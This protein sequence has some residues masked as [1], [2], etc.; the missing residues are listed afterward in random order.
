MFAS[1]SCSKIVCFFEAALPVIG[2]V[3]SCAAGHRAGRCTC[4]DAFDRRLLMLGDVRSLRRTRTRS[5]LAG[6]V[7]IVP[8]LTVFR[9]IFAICLLSLFVTGTA[10]ADSPIAA[11]NT[12]HGLAIKGYDPVSYYTTGKPTPG[13]TQFWTTYKGATYRFVSAENRDRFI[14]APEK[15]VPQYGGYCAYSISLNKIA[16]SVPDP[17]A[18]VTANLYLNNGFLAPTLWSVDKPRNIVKGDRN[19]PLVPKPGNP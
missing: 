15:F 3:G 1:E 5:C 14:A 7:M 4:L 11:V 17:W 8:L 13:L 18:T 2:P 10:L 6:A 9:Q 16:D 12:E 19:W